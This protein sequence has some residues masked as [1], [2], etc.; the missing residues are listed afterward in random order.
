MKTPQTV[1]V[2]VA[3]IG[4]IFAADARTLTNIN[5]IPTRVLQR[6][7]SP[8]FYKSLLISPV[9]GWIVVRGQL[10]GTRVSGTKV[11]HSELDGQY[12]ALAL[13]LTEEAR[14]AG[15]YSL[16][17]LNPSA[18]VL[19]HVLVYKI[20]DGIMM[21]SFANF[22]EPGGEQL[23]YFGC[24]RLAVLKNDGR[25]TEIKGPESLQGKGWAVRKGMR[26]RLVL[27]ME[28]A[29]ASQRR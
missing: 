3:F 1:I 14:I 11:I 15:F 9:E 2:L 23:E 18:S 22:D 19:V 26:N 13:R 7:I 20:A 12:D 24:A 5:A 8:K 4:S 21:L 10:V 16:D 27:K 28:Q 6:S 29:V 25:W 17:R